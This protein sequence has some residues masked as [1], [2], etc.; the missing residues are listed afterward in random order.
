MN[1]RG[2][3][4]MISGMF[5]GDVQLGYLDGTSA[6]SGFFAHGFGATSG[7]AI[8]NW[9]TPF[10]DYRMNTESCIMNTTDPSVYIMEQVNH[11][12][13]R[14]SVYAGAQKWLETMYNSSGMVEPLLDNFLKTPNATLPFVSNSIAAQFSAT[15]Q[16]NTSRPFMY[17]AIFTMFFCVLCVLPSYWG[18]WELGRKVTLGPMEIASAFQAP[19]LDHPT[20]S[21]TGGE[22]DILLKEVG[23]RRVRY[24]E[25][26]GSGRLAV[27]EPAEVK[28]LTVPSAH[29]RPGRHS[30]S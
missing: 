2:W 17:G 23:A 29:W 20:V 15:L 16:Y 28:K 14:T 7:N 5:S 4:Q 19:V 10:Y 22:V 11:I 27:A 24:G 21:R 1:I 13:F 6:V 30:Q 9:W 26:E 3:T 12:T 25:V 18:F 8:G